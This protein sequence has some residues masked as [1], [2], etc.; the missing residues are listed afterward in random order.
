M[1]MC[2][3]YVLGVVVLCMSCILHNVHLLNELVVV[4]VVV[5]VMFL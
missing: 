5:V 3:R 4:V 1:T 2:K